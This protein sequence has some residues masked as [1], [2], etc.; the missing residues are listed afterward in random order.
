[1]DP[2]DYLN[3]VAGYNSNALAL[4]TEIGLGHGEGNGKEYLPCSNF[5]LST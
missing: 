3:I 2:L 1:M 4:L 5:T